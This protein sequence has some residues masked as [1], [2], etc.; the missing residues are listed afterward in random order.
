MSR[1]DRILAP[2]P[3]ESLLPCPHCG[4]EIVEQSDHHGTWYAHNSIAVKCIHA[5][6]QLHHQ[7][8]Y[9]EW[10]MR[11]ASAETLVLHAMSGSWGDPAH[12]QEQPGD[13]LLIKRVRELLRGLS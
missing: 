10:N 9:D 11:A 4:R 13:T 12:L 1:D 2:A 6:T 7:D 8:D 5:V 3:R